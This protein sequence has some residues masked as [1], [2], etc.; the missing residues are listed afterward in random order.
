MVLLA[1]RHCAPTGVHPL[2]VY[3]SLISPGTGESVIQRIQW[4]LYLE[5]RL[6]NKDKIVIFSILNKQDS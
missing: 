4:V 6:L 3:N 1:S 5:M 2:Y